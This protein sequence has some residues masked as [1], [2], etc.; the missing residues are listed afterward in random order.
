MNESLINDILGDD[1]DHHV[2]EDGDDE[3]DIVQESIVAR[4]PMEKAM[5]KIQSKSALASLGS[6]AK[7]Q[8]SQ[9]RARGISQCAS[10][11]KQV[12]EKCTQSKEMPEMH[13][14]AYM[15]HY[16]CLEVLLN[17]N[18]LKQVDKQERTPL[19]YACAANRVDCASLILMKRS[20][21]IDK[22]DAQLDTIVHVCCFFGWHECLERVLQYGANPHGRN[23]KGFKPSHIAKNKECLE[24]LLSYGDDLIQ[25]DKVG[26]SPLFVQCA[27]NR[28]DCVEFLCEW[29]AKTQAWMI[30]QPDQRGD[31]PIHAAACNGCSGCVEV[32]RMHK[33]VFRNKCAR[34]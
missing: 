6:S 4:K 32:G 34:C 17:R 28:V 31:H 22:K 10:R 8:T 21:W 33:C 27:R 23:S 11:N 18:G 3:E 5:Y 24:L 25:G 2:E 14:A 15:G 29:D 16:A 7:I 19:F 20:D 12:C 9:G 30:E 1:I 13:Y 26:R